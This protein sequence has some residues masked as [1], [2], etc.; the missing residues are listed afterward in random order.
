MDVEEVLAD[1]DDLIQVGC[2][3][4]D[5]PNGEL[6]EQWFCGL[7]KGKYDMYVLLYRTTSRRRWRQWW[8]C[9]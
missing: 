8:K 6:P 3:K 5:V 1:E 7:S 2:D 9:Q 4:C